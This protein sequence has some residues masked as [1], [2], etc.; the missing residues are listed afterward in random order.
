MTGVCQTR[1]IFC[2]NMILFLG[3]ESGGFGEGIDRRRGAEDAEFAEVRGFQAS[4]PSA[5]L[6]LSFA[7][8]N[9]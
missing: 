8:M 3:S 5:S 2:Q 9:D 6:R 7:V 1:T 4:A